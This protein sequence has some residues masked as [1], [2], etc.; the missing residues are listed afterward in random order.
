MKVIKKCPNPKCGRSVLVEEKEQYICGLC[1]LLMTV[2]GVV[3]K[4]KIKVGEDAVKGT[5]TPDDLYGS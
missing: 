2:G 3:E 4:T 5:P 1:E